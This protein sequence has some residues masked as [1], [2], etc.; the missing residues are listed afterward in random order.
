LSARS[1]TSPPIPVGAGG[2]DAFQRAEIVVEGLDQSGPSFEARV[3]LNNPGADQ[4]TEATPDNGYV[5]SIHV[6][7]YG[8][9][10]GDVGADTPPEPD[11]VRAPM[12]RSVPA[13]DAIRAAAAR[14][15]PVTVTVVPVSYGGD[16]AG[17]RFDP[18]SMRASVAL[19]QPP[20]EGA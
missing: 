14:D 10:P 11:G 16:D 1:F 3:F 2:A 15:E 17:L 18:G 19:D 4:R 6:Y 7:G 12:T 13:T 8:L 5:G 9:W 20:Q